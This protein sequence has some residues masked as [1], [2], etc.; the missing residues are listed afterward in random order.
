MELEKRWRPLP[1]E[2]HSG[3]VRTRVIGIRR[4]RGAGQRRRAVIASSP[5]V[6]WYGQAHTANER[7]TLIDV[8]GQHP[9]SD[10]T[11]GDIVTSCDTS[12]PESSD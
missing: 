10:V 9:K 12:I 8:G 4:E 5:M 7:S 3:G 2:L 11:A 6:A 1:C